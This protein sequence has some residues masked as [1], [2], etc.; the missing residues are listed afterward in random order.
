MKSIKNFKKTIA[1]FLVSALTLSFAACG[2]NTDSAEVTSAAPAENSADTAVAD[3]AE[4]DRTELKTIRIGSGGNSGA[5]G[6]TES[7]L[8]AIKK[9]YLEEE[10]NKVGYTAEYFG[11]AQAGPA[12]NEAFAAKEID[13]GFYADFPLITAVSNN[14]DIV[15]F[16]LIN[17]NQNFAI[18][19]GSNS[20]ITSAEDLNG[21]KVIVGAGTILQKY[22]Y[23]VVNEYSLDIDSI[24]QI[25]ALQDA[26]TLI[27]SGD[28]D[29]ISYNYYASVRLASAGL[30]TIIEDTRDKPQYTSAVVAA[31]RNDWLAENKEAAK[32]IIIALNRAQEFAVGDPQGAYEAMSSDITPVSVVEQTYSYD[33]SFAY[34]KPEITEEYLSRAQDVADF[35][36]ENKLIKSEIDVHNAFDNSYAEEALLQ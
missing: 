29:A 10:L 36:Y 24:G 9:G 3:A 34:F 35:M 28:A 7:A 23:D 26:Q 18:L 11:F 2:G 8:L 27:A 21:K 1:A 30:G 6:V 12:I 5:E 13:V 14:V 17:S 15:G 22:F 16:A 31:G 20:G 19:A 4:N 33:T 25:N 32:A